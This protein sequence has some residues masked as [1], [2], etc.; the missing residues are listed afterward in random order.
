[1]NLQAVNF[2]ITMQKQEKSSMTASSTTTTTTTR[3]CVTGATGFIASH[4]ID[5]LLS[6]NHHQYIIHATVRDVNN[7]NKYKHLRDIATRKN[8]TIHFFSADL[9]RESSFDDAFSGCSVVVHI[10]SPYTLHVTD[11][12]RELIDPAVNGTL[13]VLRSCEK[14]GVKRVVLTSSTAALTDYPERGKVYTEHDWNIDSTE[15]RNPYYCSKARA[16]RTAW[17]YIHHYTDIELIVLNPC[18]VIGP[19]LSPTEC[20]QSHQ[21]FKDI[22]SGTFPAILNFSWALVDVRD[23]ARAHL[24]AIQ[25]RKTFPKNDYSSRF[26]VA[27]E[28]VDMHYICDFLRRFQQLDGSVPRRT[29]PNWIGTILVYIASLFQPKYIGQY[30]RYNINRPLVVSNKKIIEEL[31]MKFRDLDETLRDTVED[32]IRHGHLPTKEE[33]EESALLLN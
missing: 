32:L 20:N 5:Q 26:I 6:D 29:L 28:T 31:Q 1:L 27:N 21:V 8:K 10:A 4:V 23:V 16:E 25:T 24:L 33:T 14:C 2:F 22:I 9:N 13:N 11:A 17:E 30:L 15:Y 12:K 19:S 18:M 3:I 7:T